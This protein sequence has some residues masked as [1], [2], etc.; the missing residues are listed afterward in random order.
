M[1]FLITLATI[2]FACALI[3]L[4]RNEAVWRERTRVTDWIFQPGF[5]Y[6]E[7]LKV[8]DRYSYSEMVLKFW[9]PVG[10]FYKDIK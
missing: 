7:R 5:D 4:F 2:S 3:I 9:K 8:L 10:W 1:I 6:K